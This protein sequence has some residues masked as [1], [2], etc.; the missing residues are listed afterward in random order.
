MFSV[1]L[2]ARW[3]QGHKAVFVLRHVQGAS[4]H[5]PR[6][7]G[8]SPS[9]VW[10][11]VSEAR[12]PPPPASA[13]DQLRSRSQS[14][15]QVDSEVLH[16]LF[17]AVEQSE[18]RQRREWCC[19]VSPGGPRRAQLVRPPEAGE[20]W[21]GARGGPETLPVE[22]SQDCSVKDGRMASDSEGGGKQRA[23]CSPRA[24]LFVK[25]VSGE[26]RSPGLEAGRGDPECTVN[27]VAPPRRER[28]GGISFIFFLDRCLVRA[29]SMLL[30]RQDHP[31]LHDNLFRKS[32]TE[33]LVKTWP[34]AT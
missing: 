23:R 8:S 34:H 28:R 25:G 16:S 10:T 30:Q 5:L 21:D 7:L 24:A 33:Q 32:S 19:W 26:D 11:C 29:P 18:G 4:G 31:S 27:C 1:G 12:G 14:R 15:V 20:V 9:L 3:M 17:A 6:C 22:V 13:R 2:D